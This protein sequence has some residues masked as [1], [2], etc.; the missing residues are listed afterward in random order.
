MKSLEELKIIKERAKQ[1]LVLREKNYD[2]NVIVSMGECG[3][4]AG[5]REILKSFLVEVANRKLPSVSVSQ[6]DCIGECEYEPTVKIIEK[7]GNVTIYG[8]LSVESVGQIVE[9]HLVNGS[10]V[11]AL[12][13]DELKK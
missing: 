8:K 1:S 3:Y 5:A 10:V 12:T 7:S 2:T 9:Q 13:I 6:S 11:T 4:N